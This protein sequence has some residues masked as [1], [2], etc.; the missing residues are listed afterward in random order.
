MVDAGMVNIQIGIQTGSPRMKELYKRTHSN[1]RVIEMAT[2]LRRYIPRIRPPIYDFILD[3][4][5][6]TLEDKY[7]TFQLM[8]KL[9]QPF[10]VQI[11]SLTFFPGT[12]LFDLAKSEGL[13]T[14]DIRDV[15]RQQYNT[16]DINYVNLL[17]SFF[18]RPF[19]RSILR[20]MC[21][22]PA[23]NTFQRP[24]VSKVLDTM[25]NKYRDAILRNKHR[26]YNRMKQSE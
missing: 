10:F 15:Y 7:L 12:G 20:L 14:D 2:L 17:Y 16:R 13:I 19:P 11:F 21:S 22:K 24:V 3:N 9:P 26:K 18:P 4:P 1:E 5:W 6:E 25:Y 8:L 23:L